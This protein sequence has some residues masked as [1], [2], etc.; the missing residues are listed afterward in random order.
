MLIAS[1]L[2][3]MG[4]DCL[5]REEWL[6]LQAGAYK[7]RNL[8]CIEVYLDGKDPQCGLSRSSRFPTG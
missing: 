3:S 2:T 4:T 5:A 8:D 1:T 7:E 6:L